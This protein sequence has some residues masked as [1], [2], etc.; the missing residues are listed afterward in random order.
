MAPC[1]IEITIGAIRQDTARLFTSAASV[2]VVI[3]P[4]DGGEADHFLVDDAPRQQW[5]DNQLIPWM[6]AQF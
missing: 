3:N 6:K 2:E 4:H 5:T 1:L